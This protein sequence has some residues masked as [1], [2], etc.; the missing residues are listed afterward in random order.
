MSPRNRT[1]INLV[2][3]QRILFALQQN[4]ATERVAAAPTQP[5]RKRET[6]SP[7][8]AAHCDAFTK[9]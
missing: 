8:P 5:Q 2:A 3:H 1:R 9:A 7:F 6:Q 4:A